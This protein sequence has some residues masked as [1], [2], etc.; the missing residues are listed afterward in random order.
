MSP[1]T[2]TIENNELEAEL[3]ELVLIGKQWISE[4]DFLQCELEVLNKLFKKASFMISKVDFDK[5][6][7]LEKIHINLRNRIQEY[8]QILEALVINPK[9][10]IDI[11]LV[12]SYTQLA[13]ELEQVLQRLLNFKNKIFNL[14]KSNTKSLRFT[15]RI[16]CS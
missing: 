13:R 11:S 7:N 10:K 3:Q 16:E 5:R 2:T 6:N 4:L 15:N 9:H 1:I 12:D 8:L 14:N